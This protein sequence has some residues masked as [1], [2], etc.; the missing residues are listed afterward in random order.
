MAKRP[1]ATATIILATSVRTP[2]AILRTT[3][4][5]ITQIS[6]DS[7]AVVQ[8]MNARAGINVL[9]AKRPESSGRGLSQRDALALTEMAA[10]TSST[11]TP[12]AVRNPIA[13]ITSAA[14][15]PSGTESKTGI[16]ARAIVFGRALANI[17]RTGHD[18][19]A[20]SDPVGIGV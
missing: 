7:I 19:S 8:N 5:P 6:H 4:D 16:I 3:G 2:V 14:V 13:S 18:P 9:L 1:P 17:C 15:D 12:M 20:E 10:A 11:R